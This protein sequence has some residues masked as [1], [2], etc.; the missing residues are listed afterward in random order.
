MKFTKAVVSCL[1]LVFAHSAGLCQNLK[2]HAPT[3]DYKLIAHRGGVVDSVTAENSLGAL[4]KAVKRGYSMVEIDLR[5]TKDGVLI[6]N[7]DR[8][9]KRSFGMDADVS[10]MTWNQMSKL[11][12]TK[13]NKILRFED[14]LNYCKGK[15]QIMIDNKIDGNDTL[16]FAKVIDLLKKYNLYDNALMIGTDE[17]T[18]FF[19]GKI[20][21]SCT[22][23]QLEEN[24][25]KPNYRSSNYFLFSD[26]ISKADFEW[27]HQHNILAVGVIN[28][29]ALKSSDAMQEA[30]MQADKLKSS[31]LLWFQIDS[32]YDHL[33]TGNN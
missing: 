20:K 26:S 27:A 1:L 23:K 2:E 13:G 31:G 12:G 19:T 14:V 10:S 30:K 3:F 18:E 29:W 24:M 4:N 17:S 8:N 33:F 21:L 22:R 5:L 25:L 15:L 16:L 7:H 9:L 6:T 32:T 28:S 11:K